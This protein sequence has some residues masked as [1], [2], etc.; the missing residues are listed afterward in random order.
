[1]GQKVNEIY[2]ERIK[3]EADIQR[4]RWTRDRR[5]HSDIPDILEV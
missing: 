5:K 3:T 4:V 1:M 2:L